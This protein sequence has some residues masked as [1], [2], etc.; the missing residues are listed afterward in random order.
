MKLTPSL[1]AF[2]RKKAL[3]GAH[4]GI[5]KLIPTASSSHTKHLPND[6]DDIEIQYI[7]KHNN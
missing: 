2:R 5:A 3:H 6:L 1:T 7:A 4:V